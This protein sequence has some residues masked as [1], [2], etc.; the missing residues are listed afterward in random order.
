[1]EKE[2]SYETMNNIAEKDTAI[3]SD[4]RIA[5]IEEL[6]KF[7]TYEPV[8]TGVIII[9]FMPK[10]KSIALSGWR[11]FPSRYKRST[12]LPSQYYCRTKYG[13]CRH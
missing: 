5:F 4:D 11:N 13:E 6:Q 10:R 3:Y 1:M 9:V 8:K 7:E 2:I 12:D